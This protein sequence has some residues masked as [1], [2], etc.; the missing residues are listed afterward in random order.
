[1]WINGWIIYERGINGMEM[2]IPA[3]LHQIH[4]GREIT[5]EFKYHIQKDS[6]VRYVMVLLSPVLLLGQGAG[7]P[8][9]NHDKVQWK[10]GEAVSSWG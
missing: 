3:Q 4:L 2:K 5:S 9:S 8:P 6:C 7:K 10:L 1:M